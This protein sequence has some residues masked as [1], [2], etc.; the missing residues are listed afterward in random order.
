MIDAYFTQVEH[1]LQAFPNI[2]SSTL[3]TKRYNAKQ[4]YI[5]GSIDFETGCRLEFVEVKDMD[6][7]AKIKY[8]YQYMN[9]QEAC[10]FRYDNAPHHSDLPTFPHHKHTGED[11][12]ES[13]EPTLFDV[14]LEI[15]ER[16]RRGEEGTIETNDSC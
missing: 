12:E 15:A 11:V 3:T 16:E 1:V 2:R 7:L 13:R 6:C 5:K 14:L 10:I 9:P 4:G 8:R